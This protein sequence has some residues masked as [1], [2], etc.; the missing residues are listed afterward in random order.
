VILITAFGDPDTHA[1]AYELGALAVFNKPFDLDD[2]RTLVMS[3]RQPD[4]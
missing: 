1:E 3:L 2:L 4:L